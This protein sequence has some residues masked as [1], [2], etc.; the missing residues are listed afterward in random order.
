M[1]YV[2]W[3]RRVR[4]ARAEA[5]FEPPMWRPYIHPVLVMVEMVRNAYPDVETI[6][7]PDDRSN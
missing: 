1:T 6:I 3:V 7:V 5:R 4:L 2:G